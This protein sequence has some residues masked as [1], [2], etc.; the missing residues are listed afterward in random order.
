MR[1]AARV[2]R[3]LPV[4]AWPRRVTKSTSG[5]MS[6]FSAKFCSRFLEVMPQTLFLWCE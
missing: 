4:P 3:V 6:R 5:S 2:R 1:P